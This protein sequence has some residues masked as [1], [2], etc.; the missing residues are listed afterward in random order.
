MHREHCMMSEWQSATHLA[1]S[2]N[3]TVCQEEKEET[4]GSKTHASMWQQNGKWKQSGEWGKS[5]RERQTEQI[6]NWRK[7]NKRNKNLTIMIKE[8]LPRGMT[9]KVR[10]RLQKFG[11]H[12]PLRKYSKLLTQNTHTY[13]HRTVTWHAAKGML[14]WGCVEVKGADL[15]PPDILTNMGQMVAA[16]HCCD[17]LWQSCSCRHIGISWWHKQLWCFKKKYGG[18]LSRGKEFLFI[19]QGSK[20]FHLQHQGHSV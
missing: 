6:I 17:L 19:F 15:N 10:A 14:K 1:A 7:K 16:A 9:A 18:T 12:V 20:P 11:Q 3:N 13:T 4:T 5:Q 2:S 8:R